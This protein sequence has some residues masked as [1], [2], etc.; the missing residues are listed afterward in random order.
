MLVN[1][2]VFLLTLQQDTASA[3]R[4]TIEDGCVIGHM[5]HITCVD[6]VHIGKNVLTAD[7]V[8]ISDHS[9]SFSDPTIPI[10]RQPVVSKGRFHRRRKLDRRERGDPLCTIGRNCVV[11]ANAVV[12]TDIPDFSVAAGAPA[13]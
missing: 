11:G 1:K 13:R 6:E 9:H 5:N 3:P 4:M 10:I 12:L 7:R 8:Y 2:H